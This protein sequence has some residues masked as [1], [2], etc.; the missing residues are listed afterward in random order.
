MH[1]A[2]AIPVFITS[3]GIV[4]WTINEIK[5]IDSKTRKQLT[6]TGNFHPNGGVDRLFI[7]RSEGGRGLG[8]VVHMYRSRIVS[9]VRHL[10]LNKSLNSSL[11][12]VAEQEQNDIRLKEELL[13]NY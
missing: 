13:E 10:E 6:I 12:L 5:E 3:V 4:A 1:N 9:V 7:P 11:Q 2:F 8:S